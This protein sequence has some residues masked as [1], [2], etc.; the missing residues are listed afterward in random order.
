MS[1]PEP[2]IDRLFKQRFK[3]WE[4]PHEPG[5][6]NDVFNRV[7]N[8]LPGNGG[9]AGSGAE[10]GSSAAT[11][12]AKGFFGGMQGWLISGIS[13]LVIGTGA[14]YFISQESPTL[15]A[16]GPKQQAVA[17]SVATAQKDQ[18]VQQKGEPAR[19]TLPATKL[20]NLPE[21]SNQ[22]N[23]QTN[24]SDP[25]THQSG[26]G[27]PTDP[28]PKSR[29]ASADDGSANT[30]QQTSSVASGGSV[31]RTDTSAAPENRRVEA[32]P[33]E[34]F[35]VIVADTALCSNEPL[36][37]RI[38]GVADTDQ[39]RYQ[40]G[41]SGFQ[42]LKGSQNRIRVPGKTNRQLAFIVKVPGQPGRSDT[43]LVQV[44]AAPEAKPAI[45][46]QK[47]H[48]YRFRDQSKGST[49]QQW[50]LGNGA[51][52]RQNA[53]TYHYQ[54][55]GRYAVQLIASAAN[56]CMDTATQ[57]IQ[58]ESVPD[59]EIPNIFTPNGDGRNDRLKTEH[60]TLAAYELIIKNNQGK[61]VFKSSDP[62]RSWNG[63]VNNT[64]AECNQ[65]AYRYVLGYQYPFHNNMQQ[66]SGKLL[67]RRSAFK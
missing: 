29:Q 37:F 52:K 61:V 62:E 48:Q 24:P 40:L 14:A 27:K 3:S 26:S 19:L 4:A 51:Q 10:S 28:Q 44:H 38:Q 8:Q 36:Q 66:Q 49:N 13:A 47:A 18:P 56:G 7:Q 64:G 50:L 63:K 12:G 30:K 39:V 22:V 1:K 58:V 11:S 17:D 32:K 15:E 31:S 57:R 25:K 45:H 35:S 42:R 16:N 54:K 59:V 34:A 2:R 53:F 20:T 33:D 55:A 5:E 60:G 46:Q 6:V 65:G 21:S 9:S 43:Q 23:E 67:L 41:A